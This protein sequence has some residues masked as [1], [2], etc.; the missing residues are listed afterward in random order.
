MQCSSRF[1]QLPCFERFGLIQRNLFSYRSSVFIY[2]GARRVAEI[3]KLFHERHRWQEDRT[4]PSQPKARN[5]K[6]PLVHGTYRWPA[7]LKGPAT[8]ADVLRRWL[9]NLTTNFYFEISISGYTLLSALHQTHRRLA[10][11]W[12]LSIFIS[13]RSQSCTVNGFAYTNHETFRL[14]PSEAAQCVH[15]WG[16]Q[17]HAAVG[18]SQG[19]LASSS[20]LENADVLLVHCNF[21]WSLYDQS[22]KYFDKSPCNPRQ[23]EIPVERFTIRRP[24]V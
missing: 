3:H 1:P 19:L 9:V 5:Q 20:Y 8:T 2:V 12:I 16:F 24:C 11:D 17:R 21:E 18:L 10:T 4:S 6:D 15:L 22:L 13:T 7:P 14:D 23:D